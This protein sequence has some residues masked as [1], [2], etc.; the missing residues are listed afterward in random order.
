MTRISK[1]Q[2]EDKVMNK[3]YTLLF[4]TVGKK[5]N[6][7]D[8]FSILNDVLSPTEKIM[9]G[10]RVGIMF[11]L[12]KNIEYEMISDVLKVSSTTVAKFHS[13]IKKSKKIKEVLSSIVTKEKLFEVLMETWLNLR[14]PGTYGISWKS[15][16]QSKIEFEKKKKR[17]I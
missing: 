7:K 10:K 15:A 5:S 13:I 4:E 14:K 8:F 1:R 2:V 12:L 3:I 16:W 6:K 11:L 9:V 17:G